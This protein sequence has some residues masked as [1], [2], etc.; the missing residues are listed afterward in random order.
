MR[1]GL[2]TVVLLAATLLLPGCASKKPPIHPAL[3]EVPRPTPVVL[4][5][6]ITGSVLRERES[7]H[8]LWG[9]AR[10]LFW[11]R[12]GGYSLAR[13]LNGPAEGGDPIEASGPVLAVK[14][15]GLFR[16]E[17]YAP[18]VRLMESNGYRLGDLAD[19][20]ADETFFVFPYDWRYGNVE[21]SR[22]LSRA[23][24]R[25]RRARG[26]EML[27][28]HFICQSNAGR[29]VR[30]FLKFGDA[31]LEQAEA[32]LARPPKRVRAGK[33]ILVGTDNGGALDSLRTLN[34]GRTYLPLL[35]RRILPETIFTFESVFETL[36]AYGTDRFF[37]G[38][39]QALDVDLF[40]A[41]SWRRYGWSVFD[42]EVRRRLDKRSREDL[43][44]DEAARLGYLAGVLDRTRRIHALL[45][46]DVENPGDTRYYLVQN[47]YRPTGHRVM[48]TQD[49]KGEWN[50]VFS[51]DRPVSKN[52]YLYSLAT[53]P[54]DGY[55]TQESQTWISPQERAAMARPPVYVQAKHRDIIR[56]PATQRWILEFLAEP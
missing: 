24:E 27:R 28:V 7:G 14:L 17:V 36:P 11:P 45:A 43:F 25:L 50:T 55:A 30:Y 15:L 18:L 53:V 44:G 52:P 1:R 40:D 35:G 12:D 19:P 39:G 2:I 34:R 8:V 29:I 46:R 9:R 5:P 49:E 22:E 32:G 16:Y 51:S 37:D 3:V 41:E 4:L 33:L 31:S 56:H 10:N 47:A 20:G 38:D 26:E 54:G 13:P 6:G 23:L 21:A 42:P 48:L